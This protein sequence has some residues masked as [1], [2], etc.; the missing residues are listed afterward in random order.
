MTSVGDTLIVKNIKNVEGIEPPQG[1]ILELKG[2]RVDVE[3]NF[4]ALKKILQGGR[5][6]LTHR[7]DVVSGTAIDYKRDGD[8]GNERGLILISSV[9]GG[10]IPI[11][12]KMGTDAEE[13]GDA[14]IE[15]A[16]VS[17]GTTYDLAITG[18]F[19]DGSPYTPGLNDS[20]FPY[21]IP[22]Q[23]TCRFSLVDFTTWRLLTKGSN[24]P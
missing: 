5:Y 6:Q 20:A 11:S 14:I 9:S 18:T 16:N 1:K 3:G 8:T 12:L 7:V 23:T 10:T 15:I 21:T 4:Y 24:I 13:L 17:T 22:P 19:S 2:G